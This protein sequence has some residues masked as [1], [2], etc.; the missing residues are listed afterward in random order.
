MKPK[1]IQRRRTKGWRMPENTVY[2][3][4]P[5]VWGNPFGSDGGNPG[6]AIIAYREY[7]MSGIEKRSAHTGH[8]FSAADAMV[9]YPYRNRLV[10]NL[11]KLRGKNLAC[12][13][14]VGDPCHADILLAICND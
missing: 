2:V 9:G 5:S 11:G 6:D 4:R 10:L 14:K 12:W 1:R 7:V 13:C 3:G 8:L